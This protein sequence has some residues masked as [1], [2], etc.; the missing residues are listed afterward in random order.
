MKIT[1]T[2][3][4]LI[5]NL[6]DFILCIV[7]ESDVDSQEQYRWKPEAQHNCNIPRLS[8]KE[9]KHRFGMSGLP[10]LYP[11]PIIIRRGFRGKNKYFF[12]MTSQKGIVNSLPI[13]F[14][15]TLSSSNS[16]SDHRRTVPL[17]KYL[18]EILTAGE[19]SPNVLANETWYLFG[20]TYSEDWKK[21]LS[22][23]ELPPCETCVSPLVSLSFGIGNRGSG[24]QWHVHGPGF[25]EALSGRKHWL[26]YPPD[27]KPSFN[28]D[29][30]SRNWMENDYVN[31]SVLPYECTL[32]PGDLIYFPN[33]WWHATVN[34]DHYSSFIST[35]TT[36][37]EE[38]KKYSYR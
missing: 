24:V 13:N 3:A 11:H 15:V 38:L 25:A 4:L 9:L 14:E 18:D 31:L 12:N 30:T 28:P 5:L 23:Y 27:Q 22:N 35:F 10:A 7:G 34:L 19:L 16:F 2:N 32:N 6:Y 26:L 8:V 1:V 20:E 21:L 33:M 37:Y 17:T 36:E 29:Q